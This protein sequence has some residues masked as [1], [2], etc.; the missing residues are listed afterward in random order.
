VV[1]RHPQGCGAF[2]SRRNLVS[3]SIVR[4]RHFFAYGFDLLVRQGE[5]ATSH[6]RCEQLCDPMLASQF[7]FVIFDCSSKNLLSCRNETAIPKLVMATRKRIHCVVSTRRRQAIGRQMHRRDWVLSLEHELILRASHPGGLPHWVARDARADKPDV[8]CISE[9][10]QANG[11][12]S[13]FIGHT[14]MRRESVK[15]VSRIAGESFPPAGSERSDERSGSV[16]RKYRALGKDWAWYPMR[17]RVRR[18]TAPKPSIQVV[19]GPEP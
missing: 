10:G 18:N 3:P 16:C 4:E 12:K 17:H 14:L 5:P 6:V 15:V 8:Q 11:K 7:M 2:P 19:D 13:F 9:S 1:A